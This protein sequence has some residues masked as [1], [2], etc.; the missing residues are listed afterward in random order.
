MKKLLLEKKGLIAKFKYFHKNFFFTTNK[1]VIEVSYLL[2]LQ[3]SH[4]SFYNSKNF[5]LVHTICFNFSRVA[6]VS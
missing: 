2:S 6:Y 4:L 1:N 5:Y 3:G